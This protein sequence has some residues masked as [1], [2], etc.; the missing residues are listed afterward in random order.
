MAIGNFFQN[1][2][3]TNFI[4]PFFLMFFIVFAILEKTKL[5]GEGRRQLNALIALIIS[6]IFVSVTAPKLIVSNLILFLTIAIV[7]V[8]VALLLWGF[9][10]GSDMKAD[11]L[12]SKT[13]KGI[14]AAVVII[15]VI[16]AVIWAAGLG[17]PVL[18]FLKKFNWSGEFF[19]NLM[20][21]IVIAVA[22][23]VAIKVGGGKP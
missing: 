15:A 9:V 17:D 13:I 10:S 20:F 5:L 16:F 3:L 6:L 23:A 7:V 22:L 4:Y 2:I 1:E 18:D 11:F 21:V 19:T 12:K 8:F 14:L